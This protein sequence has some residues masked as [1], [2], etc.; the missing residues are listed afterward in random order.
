MRFNYNI[1]DEYRKAADL[2]LTY[3]DYK[4]Q[5]I[6]YKH[7][8]QYK[9][10]TQN[11]EWYLRWMYSEYDKEVTERNIQLRQMKAEND[12]RVM[13]K[14]LMRKYGVIPMPDEAPF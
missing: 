14:N 6:K 9:N 12:E 13:L 2:L 11:D 4:Y 7:Y 1:P 5:E 3:F 10:N 8:Q